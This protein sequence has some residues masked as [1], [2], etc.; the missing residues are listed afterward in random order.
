MKVLG[1]APGADPGTE[2]RMQARLELVDRVAAGTLHV[3]VA[4]TYPLA[5]VAAAH[6]ESASGHVR[7]K[8][9]LLP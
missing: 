5:D 8:L 7:G 4:R 3:V 6:R 1:G 2:I 9:A